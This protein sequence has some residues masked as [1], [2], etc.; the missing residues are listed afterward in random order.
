[1]ENFLSLC[2]QSCTVVSPRFAT[3][4]IVEAMVVKLLAKYNP[5]TFEATGKNQ[6]KLHLEVDWLLLKLNALN[7]TLIDDS[8]SIDIIS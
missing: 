5:K 2:T 8:S 6:R 4:P 1:M 3:D 7:A